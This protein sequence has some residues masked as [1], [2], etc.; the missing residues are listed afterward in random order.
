MENTVISASV[1]IILIAPFLGRNI[2]MNFVQ[3]PLTRLALLV[4]VFY[5]IRQGP[6]AGLLSFLAAFSIIIERNHQVLTKFPHQMP[7]WPSGAGQQGRPQ[8]VAP[9]LATQETHGYEPPHG[10]HVEDSSVVEHHGE[11]TTEHSYESAG[12]IQDSNPRLG[13]VAQGEAAGSFYEQ[14]GLV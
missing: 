8:V 9:L 7:R 6:M 11:T 4:F 10:D 1:I 5:G 12:D 2:S 3:N 13:E 14:K